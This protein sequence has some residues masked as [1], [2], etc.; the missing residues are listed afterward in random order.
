MIDGGYRLSTLRRTVKKEQGMKRCHATK[1]EAQ[2]F[3]FVH[4]PLWR[5]YFKVVFLRGDA[6][7]LRRWQADRAGSRYLPLAFLN[8]LQFLVLV[9]QLQKKKISKETD[10]TRPADK[11][12]KTPELHVPGSENKPRG[13]EKG[14]SIFFGDCI[15]L[16]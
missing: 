7:R 16:K 3:P 10:A 8:C 14:V 1:H 15:A 12:L 2:K 13:F 4:P 9:E 11:K 6:H 5:I